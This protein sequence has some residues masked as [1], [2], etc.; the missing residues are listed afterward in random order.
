[1]RSNRDLT[2]RSVREESPHFGNASDGLPACRL[3]GLVRAVDG[4]E[5]AGDQVDRK[6]D[7]R[8]SMGPWRNASVTPSSTAG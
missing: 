7:D 8:K 4:M 2:R 6:I 5:L 3:C 1:M